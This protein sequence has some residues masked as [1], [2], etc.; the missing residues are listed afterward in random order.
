MNIKKQSRAGFTLVELLVVITIIG[1][2][3]GLILPAIGAARE[4][5]NA[6]Q[7]KN[8]LKQIGLAAVGYESNGKGF[9]RY[10]NK[11]GNRMV[12]WQVMLVP[13]LG[14]AEIYDQYKMRNVVPAR[15]FLKLFN[16]PSDPPELSD[17]PSNSYVINAGSATMNPNDE[18]RAD[19]ISFA[20]KNT[21]IDVI[22]DGASN[23]LLFA[24]NLLATTW[25]GA[26]S[27]PS[28][29]WDGAMPSKLALTFMWSRTP[30]SSA[31]VSL[32]NGPQGVRAEN[33]E[34]S[35][36]TAR[37]SSAH[38]GFVNVAYCDGRA[39][40]LRDETDYR[41]LVQLMTSNHKESSLR[42][43]G[44]GMPPEYFNYILDDSD[45]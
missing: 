30:P 37:P 16:C 28:M 42:N 40:Q 33:L 31:S 12:S 41:V 25:D 13:N 36:A 7:C 27:L 23:T 29:N 6:L 9:P 20:N 15:P 21:P 38:S 8:N 34:L 39:D 18:V 43:T 44:N 24:E 4:A 3:M 11:L 35:L 14:R 32:I 10:V 26:P 19:G 17:E 2:L 22:K 45:Y 1:I 5:A